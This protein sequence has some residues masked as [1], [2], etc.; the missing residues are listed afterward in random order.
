MRVATRRCGLGGRGSGWWREPRTGATPRPRAKAIALCS[1]GVP[2]VFPLWSRCGPAL[3]NERR[4]G[5]EARVVAQHVD[6][7]QHERLAWEGRA[8]GGGTLMIS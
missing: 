5:H 8:G 3:T 6:R 2:A 1:R 4:P 7:V